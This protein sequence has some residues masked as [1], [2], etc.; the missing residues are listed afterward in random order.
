MNKLI[1]HVKP[2]KK[3]SRIVSMNGNELIVELS[4]KPVE[5]EANKELLKLLKKELGYNYRIV[6]GFRSR[7]KFLE[8]ID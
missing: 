2:N 7:I 3:V 5:G 8:R 4:A 6:K 1:V